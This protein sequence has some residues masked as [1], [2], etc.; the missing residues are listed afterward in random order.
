LKK[1][2]ISINLHKGV[3]PKAQ[4]QGTCSLY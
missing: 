4:R 1:C 3:N 2:I